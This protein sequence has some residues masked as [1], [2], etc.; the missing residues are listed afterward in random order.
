MRLPSLPLVTLTV[1]ALVLIGQACSR[2]GPETQ[3]PATPTASPTLS[4]ATTVPTPRSEVA[5]STLVPPDATFRTE[6]PCHDPYPDEAPFVSTPDRPILLRPLG[7]SPALTAHR[8]E[9]PDSDRALMKM[10]RTVL[11]DEEDHFAIVIKNLS[12]GTGVTFEPDRD[13]YAASLYKTWVM[14]EAFNQQQALLLDWAEQ[15]IVSDHYVTFGL[16]PGELKECDVV[17]L[18]G[19]LQRMMGRTDNVAANLLL[20]RVGAGNINR[21]LHNLGL[22]LS[23]FYTVGTMP[24]TAVETALLLEAIYEGAAVND[25][26]SARMLELLKTESIDDRIPALLPAGTA[27]AHK[28]GNWKDATHDVG[29]VFSPQ[30]TYLI[31]VLTDYGYSEGGAAPIA[32]LSRV[33]YDYYNSG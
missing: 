8:F 20:D 3:P 29:I 12:D 6:G 25:V 13:F 10:V 14:L 31:V 1:L 22:E 28:T 2:T 21:A 33:V 17:S 30:A 23:G 11:G 5:T 9:L 19:A 18:L 32:E 7:Q 16:N 27:V 26:A 4:T 15:Y 24:T